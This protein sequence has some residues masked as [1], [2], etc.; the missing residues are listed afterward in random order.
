MNPKP[1]QTV[2]QVALARGD[3]Y[4]RIACRELESC[5]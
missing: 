2:V 5:R 3:L 1:L 4:V